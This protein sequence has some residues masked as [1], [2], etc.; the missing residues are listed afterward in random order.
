MEAIEIK[1]IGIGGRRV[2]LN[3]VLES[4]PI[5]FFCPFSNVS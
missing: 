1:L 3:S 5:L 4:I 2:F